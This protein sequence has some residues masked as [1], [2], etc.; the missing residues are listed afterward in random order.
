[1]PSEQ[2]IIVK[3]NLHPL[4]ILIAGYGFFSRRIRIR[5]LRK[6]IRMSIDK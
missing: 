3:V 5:A 4:W 2:F 1:M 6:A